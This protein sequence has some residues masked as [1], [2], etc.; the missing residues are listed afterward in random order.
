MLLYTDRDCCSQ[1][2]PSKYLQLF[3]QWGGLQVRLDVWHFMRRLAKGCTSE[4]HPLY[5]T[6]MARLSLAVFEWD[7][8]DYEELDRVKRM[9]MIQAGIAEP[10]QEAVRRAVTK[11]ELER[12]CRRTRPGGWGVQETTALIEELLLS[13]SKATDTLGVPL[14]REEM[15]EIWGEQRKHVPCLQDPEG[16]LQLFALN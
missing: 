4:S 15:A 1:E 7:K 10:S 14:L 8:D 3:S 11:E 2:G 12:H 5:G 13:L 6:F 16:T 9:E